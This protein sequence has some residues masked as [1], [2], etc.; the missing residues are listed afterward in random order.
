MIERTS[1]IHLRE[2]PEEGVI[3]CAVAHLEWIVLRGVCLPWVKI[4][5]RAEDGILPRATTQPCQ[6]ARRAV[7]RSGGLG[8]IADSVIQDLWMNSRSRTRSVWGS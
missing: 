1:E 2:E 4:G 5:M 3:D 6:P 7:A 8:S